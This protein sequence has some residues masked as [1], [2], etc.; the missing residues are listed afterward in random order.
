VLWGLNKEQHENA[1]SVYLPGTKASFVVFNLG[2]KQD[3]FKYWLAHEYGHCLSLHLLQDKLGED[4]AECFAKHLV[5]PVAA[6]EACISELSHQRSVRSKMAHAQSWA[7]RYGVSIVTVLKAVDLVAEA[8]TGTHPGLIDR[9]F[10]ASWK[11]GRARVPSVAMGLFG[12]DTP[13]PKAYID[14][15]ERVFGSRVFAAL[16]E[17]QRLEGRNPAFIANTLMVGLSD[18]I[19]LSQELWRQKA[20]TGSLSAAAL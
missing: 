1:L 15:A 6:A 18:A 11:L 10:W 3:D 8:K 19:G 5:F 17:F 7:D 2:C 16:A 12:T 9:S 14:T 20:S 13:E 4:Y